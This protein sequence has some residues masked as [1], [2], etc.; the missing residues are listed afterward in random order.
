MCLVVIS[1]HSNADLENSLVKQ[2]VNH[3]KT[4]CFAAGGDVKNETEISLDL[5]P[6]NLLSSATADKPHCV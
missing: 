6:G 4:H 1:A 3:N 5:V 2:Y